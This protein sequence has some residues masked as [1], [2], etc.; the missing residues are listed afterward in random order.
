MNVIQL[1]IRKF[2][3]QKYGTL[4][5]LSLQKVLLYRNF[6][7]VHSV[8]LFWHGIIWIQTFGLHLFH[9]P[10]KGISGSQHTFIFILFVKIMSDFHLYV[11]VF[12]ELYCHSQRPLLQRKICK[13]ILFLL[14]RN[15]MPSVLWCC[16]LGVRKSIRPVKIWL[17]RCWH[18][19]LL[20]Q[21]A[22]SLH[23][24]QLMPLSPHHVCFCKIQNGLSFWYWLTLVIPDKGS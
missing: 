11:A 19:Y 22:N 17:M 1:S 13:K 23:M 10:S 2:G 21:S 18:G 6:A 5:S 15:V 4:S 9:L 7:T 3:K 8:W 24:V 16:W 14:S 20:Q 12:P